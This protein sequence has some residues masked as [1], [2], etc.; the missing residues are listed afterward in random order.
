VEVELTTGLILDEE[1][2]DLFVATPRPKLF[3]FATP[4]VVFFFPDAELLYA[5]LLSALSPAVRPT[6]LLNIPPYAFGEAFG[7]TTFLLFVGLAFPV[8]FFGEALVGETLLFL[9]L[10]LM[11]VL[12]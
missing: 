2:H 6:V 12:A 7:L 5:A 10:F 11:S 4:S 1:S 8:T 3:D 9:G